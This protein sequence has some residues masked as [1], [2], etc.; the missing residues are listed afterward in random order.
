MANKLL[1]W[2]KKI[3]LPATLVICLILS[4]FVN[5]QIN[6]AYSS[7]NQQG[8]SKLLQNNTIAS[9]P[10]ILAD[11]PDP[12]IIR[13]GN[14]YY[15]VSTTMHMTPGV[16][17]MHSTDLV[18]WRI[19]GY[20]YDRLEDNDAHNLKNGMNI[21]GKGQWAPCIRYYKGKF[22]V[23]F[24][25]LD[26]GK[27][28]LFSSKNITGPWERVEFN[29]YLH[30]PS[31]LFDDNGKAYIIYGG[32]EI[33]VKELTPDLKA[34]NPKGI[35][36]VI[37]KS[38]IDGLE[39][40]SHA[41]KINGKYYITT[42]RWKKGGI[43]EECVYRADKIDGPYEGR[44]VLSDTLGYKNNGVAQGGLIDTPDGKW[45]A[46][47]F[48]DHDAVGRVPVLVPVRWENG[49]PV[50][51]DEK[52]K[53]PLKFVKPGQSSF[54]TEVVKSDEFYQEKAESNPRRFEVIRNA[55]ITK[56]VELVI[57]NNF[58]RGTIGWKGRE[59]AKLEVVR[60]GS[61][62]I[63]HVYNR[64]GPRSGI[65]QNLTGRVE[66]GKKYNAVFR[67]KYVKGPDTKE[68]IL[69]AKITSNGKESYQELIKGFANKNEW[70]SISG[71]FTI[72]QDIET[73]YL[74]IQTPVTEK[75]DKNKDL[76]DYY[77]EYVSI[78]EV[79]VTQKE[80]EEVA[81]NGS[82][83]D[84]T[85]QWN[86]NPDNSKWSLLERKGFLRLKTCNVVSDIQQ[87]RN[88]LTQRTLGPKC[89][90]WILMDVR[91][92]KDGDY[93]GLAA[94]QKEYGFIGV[95]KQ[96]K[97]FYIV[98]VEKGKEVESTKLQ[99]L[100][101][102][103]K[104]DFDFEIDKAYFYYSYDG[105]NWIKFGSDLAM[106]YTIPHF[107]GYRFAIF[108][109][110]T[111]QTG[112]YV[113]IDFFKFSSK[114][115]GEKT[116]EDLKAYLKEDIIELSN[117]IDKNYELTVS[118]NSLPK[119]K[120]MTQIKILLKFPKELDVLEALVADK[121]I[122]NAVVLVEKKR[123][124]QALINIK[125]ID[126]EALDSDNRWID[127]VNIK[128]KQ[129]EKLTE[130]FCDEIRIQS[131]TVNCEKEKIN[132]RSE[133][134]VTK[135]KFVAPKNPIGKI[136]TNAN[137][138][139]AHKFGADPAVL[140]Y[141]DRVYIYLT[142]D[143][144]EYD[145]NGNIKD[146][147]YSKINKI[148][149]ISSDDLVN[150]TD[151][152][153][154]EV[155]GP[156]GIAKWATQSWAPSIAYKKI[157]GKDKFFLYFANNASGIGVLTSDT[158]VGPWVDP[159][160]KPLISRSTPGVE[161]VVWLFDPA[162]LVDDDGKA[163]IYFGGGV[164]QG[165][166]A[167]PNTA[168]VMQLGSDMISVVGSAV[169]IPAPFMFEDSGIN[170]IG[171]TYYYSYCTNFYSG[172]RP[173]GSPPAGVI[174]YMTSKS[175][176]GPWEYKGVILKNPGNFFGVGGNNHHQLFEFNGKWYIAYH[177]Q[178]LAK[179]MGVA[180]GYRSPHIN[181]V[182]IENGT[183]KEVIADYRGIAQVKNFDP[184][185]MV[186]AETFAWCAGISTK[187]ANGSNDMCL[188]GIDSG[189]W[190]ALSKVDFGSV[191]PQKFEAMVSNINGKGY[192]EIK[193]DSVDGRTIAV[194]EVLPQNS[195]TSQWVKIEAKV[196]NVTGAHD[197]Y[198]V[199][200]GEKESN[201]FDMDCWRFVK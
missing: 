122:K 187:K 138:L 59:G 130:S 19:I 87:A 1:R 163:Y 147:T 145:D 165:Q 199:F 139:I 159:I 141:K 14:D 50:F 35:N 191:G 103:L 115:T 46:M 66:K 162:V 186:E 53:V 32:S 169:T 33:R 57:N 52:G 85:W 60:E 68:F 126:T 65:Q 83:L 146:N 21:Y 24:G 151:H 109:F 74:F 101:V 79:L 37:I 184:Y 7:S 157:N 84:L 106:R 185:R 173:Q 161:G 2:I 190:I 158:P 181:Q 197:L 179:D 193:I 105:I 48:Q 180:K 56:D 5:F 135:V 132:Y 111:K 137:P 174:A 10:I 128:L 129:R 90:G 80:S 123:S 76:I 140:V 194:A 116:E 62:N 92:M 40:G 58:A 107:M 34:I 86:H 136:P 175:P 171:N 131:L 72:S 177:A 176:M 78:K 144:L 44:V 75:P 3:I 198:F 195:S 64:T 38:K 23:L 31:L 192:I 54:E 133:S 61:K 155:A 22:Y 77:V 121:R 142:N 113:D 28:Y 16:P 25:A 153:E 164:P 172:A 104:I 127:L 36:K 188:T 125:N 29:E 99:Q 20:V 67:V 189:D 12:D 124:D 154:I 30:D 178:T 18:N 39:E 15:M 4:A 73:V 108:N 152:G 112:G 55:E 11:I 100:M 49:W 150:W 201:L 63:I 117:D 17:I 43:R 9:N 51:G 96:G 97:E 102:Y 70:T 134:A 200:K 168:R 118:L 156:N 148:T 170:K 81:P 94:F 41:Y 47:L 183:I 143:I 160:G 167:M 8:G 13:V 182:E 149:I 119:G 114:L 93:A 196:E 26:T 45:Y 71:T 166:D 88:T 98:M 120:K 42:I 89:S 6:K 27:T 110:A 91:N 69:A 95:K 82:V